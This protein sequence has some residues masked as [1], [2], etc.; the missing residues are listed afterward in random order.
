MYVFG[1]ALYLALQFL[2][3]LGYK[4][5]AFLDAQN[6][7]HL[8]FTTQLTT[9]LTLALTCCTIGTIAILLAPLLPHLFQPTTTTP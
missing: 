8:L 6:L 4:L 9:L 3:Y 7:D 2:V 5:D 1:N